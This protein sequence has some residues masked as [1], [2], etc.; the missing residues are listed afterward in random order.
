[1]HGDGKSF[2]KRPRVRWIS[3]RGG[4]LMTA[5]FDGIDDLRNLREEKQNVGTSDVFRKIRAST[6]PLV[7]LAFFCKKETSF[8][9][10][11]KLTRHGL[12]GRT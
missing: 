9:D 5:V 7:C 1:M 11:E 6:F 10:I 8:R 2:T 12:G 4:I 3:V